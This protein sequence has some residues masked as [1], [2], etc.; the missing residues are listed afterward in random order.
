MGRMVRDPE[1]SSNH[2]PNPT[3]GPHG[4]AEAIRL[5]SPLKKL[6]EFL[7]LLLGKPW[8]WPWRHTAPQSFRALLPGP[9]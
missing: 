3:L 7:P 9:P 8:L 5:G 4:S 6:R 1:G 2:F